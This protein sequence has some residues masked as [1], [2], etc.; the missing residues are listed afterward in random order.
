MKR[1]QAICSRCVNEAKRLLSQP[2][3]M[4]H[5]QNVTGISIE[6][7]AKVMNKITFAET[8]LNCSKGKTKIPQDT[9]PY[10]LELTLHQEGKNK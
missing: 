5:E 2:V 1:V 4:H 3:Y 7:L 6:E 9:C 8:C 10:I